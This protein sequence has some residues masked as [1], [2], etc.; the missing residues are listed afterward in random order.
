MTA[1]GKKLVLLIDIGAEG[2]L[3]DDDGMPKQGVNP[4]KS[5]I[6]LA[7]PVMGK[8]IIDF[9]ESAEGGEKIDIFVDAGFNGFLDLNRLKGKFKGA[10]ICE[11]DEEA[12]NFYYD[13]FTVFCL[14]AIEKDK[15]R[16][17]Y[18]KSILKK[19][20]KAGIAAELSKPS[21]MSDFE[22]TATGHAHLDLGWLWPIRETKRKA[23]RTLATALTNIDKYEGYVFG[24]S[25]PQMFEWIKN[26]Y[27]KLYEKVKKAVYDGRIEPQGGMWAEADTNVP[28]GESL[29]RQMVY[30]KEFF[31]KEFGQDM[32]ICWLPDVFGFSGALPQIIKKCGMKYFLTIKLSWCEHN[33]FP[34]HSFKWEGIDDSEIIVHMPPDGDYNNMATPFN[35]AKM[36]R[37]YRDKDKTDKALILYGV[38]DG[39]GGPGEA[40]IEFI[41]R[42]RNLL[43]LPEVEFGTADEFFKELEKDAGKFVKYK[44]ELYLEKH[45]G[46]L[47]TQAK[48]KLYN[49]MIERELHNLEALI[50]MQCTVY[51]VQCTMKDKLDEIWKEVLL[52]QFHDIIPGSSIKRVYDESVA[53]YRIMLDEVFAMQA[54]IIEKLKGESK[55]SAINLTSFSRSEYVEHDGKT[56][57]AKVAPYSS[58]ELK[59]TEGNKF[60]ELIY[61]ENSIENAKLKVVFDKGGS[62]SSIF[63]KVNN[64]E[65]VKAG[66]N[67]LVIYG[68][69]AYN[70]YHAWDIDINY[71]KKKKGHFNLVSSKAHIQGANVIM[72]QEY[73]YGKSKLT[74]KISLSAGG[75]FVKFATKVDWQETDLM[76]RAEVEPTYFADKVKCDIQFGN[77]ERTT[78]TDDKISWAQFEIAAHKW[79]DVSDE[80]AN[81]GFAVMNDCKYGHRVKNGLISLNLL[82]STNHPDPTADRGEQAFTY[83]FYPHKGDAYDGGVVKRAYQLN[84]PLQITNNKLQITNGESFASSDAKN[85]IIETIKRSEKDDGTIIR[86]YET[87]GKNT[88]CE[89]K[90][91]FDFKEVFETDMLENGKTS[92]DISKIKIKPFEIKTLKIV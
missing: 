52:Y 47:T 10:Y 88:T 41:S 68:D 92:I 44:G 72:E 25:Q 51:S 38:G 91:G 57:L 49:R 54:E 14:F 46:T 28:S 81:Y 40:H 79:V 29:I 62:I 37:E 4:L 24:A 34:R 89:L 70:E 32:K 7:Q 11:K 87:E 75:V 60:D 63:D 3:F 85:V 58:S 35:L 55:P 22:V 50:A 5:F 27:P 83:A 66:A 8:K 13:F 48:N 59:E 80:K 1:K 82:R 15:E 67:R 84:N 18:L 33:K 26:D 30:G 76:L 53:R 43:P 23:A 36:E 31:N 61:S 64:I 69:K 78:K 20:D 74:Q 39:G 71:P 16:R 45:Q 77:I 42:E 90:L 12:F 2:L 73:A 17:K 56:Y 21:E 65:S 19:E 6:D 86:I 9:K